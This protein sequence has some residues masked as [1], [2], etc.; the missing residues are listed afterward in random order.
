VSQL[1]TGWIETPLGG[2][3]ETQLGKMLSKK[4][5]TGVGSRPYL[6]NKNVQWGRFDLTDVAEMDFT[7]GE[8]EKFRLRP[9]DLLVCEGGEVGRA[10]VWRGQ[11][12]N[13]TYQKAIHRVRP[14]DGVLADYL[15]YVLEYLA[16]THALEPHI[17]GSTIKHLP[18]EDLRILLVPLAPT[19]EQ[20][21]IVGAI[22]EQLSRL[23]AAELSLLQAKQKLA[24]FRDSVRLSLLVGDWQYKTLG[25][26]SSVITKGTTPTSVG[27]K[28]A[29]DGVLFVKAE[30]LACGIV[31]HERCARIDGDADEALRRSRLE[32]NDVLIT[33]AGTLGRI[34]LVRDVDLPANTNQAVAL[35]RLQ[36]PLTARFV[37]EWLQSP[38]ARAF[39]R[40]GGRGVGLQNL[41]LKQIAAVPIPTLPRDE[42]HRILA[43]LERQLSIIDAMEVS[44]DSVL[45][46]SA[47]LRRAILEQAFTGRLLQ[48]DPTDE[49]ASVLLDRITAGGDIPP[50]GRK[51]RHSRGRRSGTG[52]QSKFGSVDAHE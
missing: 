24:R 5:K 43:E 22:E 4:S 35:A 31:R 17:T 28:Y 2:I 32:K 16:N 49:H 13:C 8:F 30:S 41:N 51:S 25:E 15:R 48:Q 19:N 27:F 26:I 23:D 12:D 46:R 11:I 29:D 34:G 6:R 1:P 14:V 10:A 42:Q 39:L 18:Q 40:T 38:T 33:I 20:R 3:A 44:I 52:A 9:G 37:V 47:T 7:D 45:K 21:R 36:D 50:S